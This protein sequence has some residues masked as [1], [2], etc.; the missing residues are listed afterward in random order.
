LVI[1]D[2]N[3]VVNIAQQNG[4]P[5]YTIGLDVTSSNADDLRYIATQTGGQ[6][7]EAPN[8]SDLADVYQEISQSI[9]QE[10]RLTYTTPNSQE[11]GTERQVDVTVQNAGETDSGSGFYNA[12]NST[13]PDIPTPQVE[14]D[15]EVNGRTV[16]LNASAVTDPD[17]TI[18]EYRWDFENDGV[19][20]ATGEV[21]THTYNTSGNY[22]VKLTAVDNTNVIQQELID[23]SVSGGPISV[24][25]SDANASVG[26]QAAVDVTAQ[27]A[28]SVKI[29]G[30]PNNWSVAGSLDDNAFV[31]PGNAGDSIS[32]QGTV[33]W[34]WSDD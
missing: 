24:S 30:I 1:T 14:Q 33:T 9:S 2:R 25:A 13:R 28:G 12:P 31:T 23:V 17:G 3:E 11:D 20:D 21:V 10:Y 27:N 26:G 15:T 8:A 4:V 22:E 29:E 7:Y 19:V 16:T 32:S 34:A 18:V 6:Y 5:V